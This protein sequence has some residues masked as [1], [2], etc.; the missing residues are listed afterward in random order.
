MRFDNKQFESNVSTTMSTLDKL[1]Q[2]LNFSG[3]AK[4]LE[5]VGTAAKNVNMN[6]LGDAVHAVSTKFS[7]MQ[8]MAVTALANITNSAINAG[9]RMVSALTI[10]PIKTGFSEYETQINATQT[11]L[12]NTQSKGSTIDDVNAALEEL[13]KYAD[14]TIYN[15]T[16]MTRNIGTFTAAGVDLETSVGA[17]QGIANLAAVSGSTSQQASTA[18][19]Q[20][21]QALSSGTVRLQ[22][23]NSVVNAGMGGEVFQN[24]LKKTSEQLGTGAEQAI[25]ASGSFRESLRDGWL[26]S[27]V[28]TE[29]LKKFTTSGANEYLAEYTGQ[30]QDVVESYIEQGKEAA[31]AA[32]AAG[33]L[34]EGVTEE[35]Y[36][37]DHASKALAEKSGK[38]QKEIK[39]TLELAQ[40]ATDAATKVKTFT[41]LWDVLKESAQSGWSQTWKI[42]VGDF[43]EAKGLLTPIAD[44]LTGFINRMSEM[45]NKIIE[46]ALG[47]GFADLSEKMKNVL[48]PAMKATD[49]LKETVKTVTDLG[50][51]VNKVIR[52]DFGNGE[53]RF[54]ALA[55][56]GY[57][58]CEVQNKVNETLGNSYRYTQEQIDAQNELLGKKKETAEASEEEG[59]ATGKLTDAQ[60]NRLKQLVM[61]TEEE[62]EAIGMTEE[63]V[64]AL[65]ELRKTAEK[66][67]MPLD[68]FIDKMDEI[69]GRWLMIEGF[70][71]LG[72]SIAEIFKSIGSAFKEIFNPGGEEEAANGLFNLIA[73][74]HKLSRGILDRVIDKADELKRIFKGIFAVFDIIAK[75]TGGALKI[76]FKVVTA[77]L[78][79]F[80]LS[81][82]DV[83][84]WI[85]DAIVKFRDWIDRVFD[86]DKI[87]GKLANG[88]HK[89]I[90]KIKTFVE[91]IKNSEGF[92]KFVGYLERTAEA[93]K[94]FFGS[95]K[96]SK[97]F[98]NMASAFKSFG[99]SIAKVFKNLKNSDNIPR[100]IILGLINGIKDGIPAIIGAMFEL[101]KA[102]LLGICE[103]LGIHSPSREFKEVGKNIVDGLIEGIKKGMTKVIEILK[104]LFGKVIEFAKQID[105]GGIL[106]AVIVIG[107]MK[108]INNLTGVLEPITKGMGSMLEGIGEAFQGLGKSLKAS[109]LKKKATAVLLFA[110]AVG[111]LA[112][113]LFLISKIPSKDLWRSVGALGALVGIVIVLATA[114]AGFSIATNKLEKEKTGTKLWEIALVLVGIGAAVML[115]A[116][117]VKTLGNMDNGAIEKGGFAIASFIAMAGALIWF[118]KVNGSA[119]GQV[120]KLL[121]SFSVSMFILAGVI[122]IFALMPLTWIAKG[123]AAIAGLAGIMAG[124]I[125]VTSKFESKGNKVAAMLLGA[126]TA[127]TLMA[128]ILWLLAP[129]KVK[130]I[131]KGELAMLGFVGIIGA[132]L[133]V[134]NL[135]KD[136]L[137][138]VSA[139]ILS[140]G[141]T[142]LI[143]ALVMKIC[144]KMTVKQIT[145]GEAVIIS[146]AGIISALIYM[147]KFAG[148][149]L[150]SVAV[151]L[152]AAAGAIAI[153]AG[154]AILLGFIP[155][156]NLKKG[157]TAVTLLGGLVVG[158]MQ[159]TRGLEQCKGAVIAMAVI[160]ALLAGAVVG[161][162]FIDPRKLGNAVVA[163]GT[164]IGMMALMFLAAGTMKEAKFGPIIAM[165]AMVVL[166][167]GVIW[168]LSELEVDTAFGTLAGIALVMVAMAGIVAL[169]SLVGDKASKAYTGIFALLLMAAP[170]LAFTFVL[171]Q[172]NGVTVSTETLLSLL[173]VVTLM[174]L[175]LPILAAVG[176]MG[177]GPAL[178]GVLALSAM[179]VPLALFALVLGGMQGLQNAAAN[180]KILMTLMTLMTLLL[181]PLLLIGAAFMPALMGIVA[182]GAM[183]VPMASYVGVLALMQNI[184]GAAENTDLLLNLMWQLT[185]M[186]LVLAPIGPL[187]LI[188]SGV[189]GIL[190]SLMT[191]VGLLAVA[192]GALFDKF[193][194]LQEFLNTGLPVMIQLAGAMGEMIGAFVA[195]IATQIASAL[196]AIAESMSLFMT[197]LQGFIDGAKTVD[198]KVLAGVAIIVA[199][200]LALSVAELFAAISAFLSGGM[201][202]PVLG[203][204]L[205]D[206]MVNAMPFVMTA[207]LIKPS[208]IDGVKALVSAIMM[209]TGANLLESITSW[210]TGE[211]SMEAFA[212]QFPILGQGLRGFL[213]S[214]GVLGEEE[215]ATI[216]CASQA[217]KTLAEASKTI[218]NTGGLLG[219]LVGNNDLG[220][221]AAQFPILGFGLRQ[222]LTNVGTF[223]DDE[224]ATVNCAAEA[225]KTLAESA[226]KIPNQGGLLADLIGDN[227][228]QTFAEQ[229]PH[230]GTGLRSFLT[231]V[232]TFTDAE[233][234]TVDCGARA[235]KLL[236]EAASEIPN[237]GGWWGKIAGENNLQH[238]ANQFPYL[239]SGLVNFL[240]S[241]GD[242]GFGEEQLNV[243]KFGA[244]AVAEIAKAA[245]TIPNSGGWWGKIVGENNLQDFAGQFPSLGEGLAGFIEKLGTFSEAQVTTVNAAAR[246]ITA[247]AELDEAK[248][249]EKNFDNLP[250][251]AGQ[252]RTFCSDVGGIT[253]QVVNT[254]ARNVRTIKTLIQELNTVD[255]TGAEDFADALSQLGNSS[256]DAFIDAFKDVDANLKMGT[257]AKSLMNKAI[258]GIEAKKDDF[259]SAC[260]DVAAAGPDAIDTTENVGKFESAGKDLGAGLVIGIN[261]KWQAVYDAAYALGQAAVQGEKDGQASNSPS[262]LTIQAGKWLGEGLVVGMDMMGNKVYNAGADLGKAATGNI[263]STISK[264]ADAVNTDIDSQP[265]IR[266]VL[267]L[268]DVESGA[269]AIGNMLNINPS[270]GVLANVG[271]ISSAMNQRSQNGVNDDV[272]SAIDRLNKKMNNFGNTTYHI[273]G[274]TYDDGSNISEAVRTIVRAARIERRV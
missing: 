24:A 76:A 224:I 16:E 21:S 41:Q 180:A 49:A 171:Q 148:Q 160:I 274:V 118:A 131:V 83:A 81:I 122:G 10:D 14:M 82:L 209:I 243:V 238:F 66:L 265:T 4:G 268:S 53:P 236:A 213:D 106:S 166:L 80:G 125:I 200:I 7:A 163:M 129:M 215:M 51:I 273:D 68:E 25:K 102:I 110:V 198:E 22:D 178:T 63:Q 237:Q 187:A 146:F 128:G 44:T 205:S 241:F 67:G 77:V 65:N 271:S 18:M 170:L 42:I 58:Y 57:N 29:T 72:K 159:S 3:S 5:D 174:T 228:M 126:A 31:K 226:K 38:N 222:F 97:E 69:D 75:I 116:L 221:F 107:I 181:I 151:T 219:D 141:A 137:A 73:G 56:A 143:M 260:T 186:L 19:Y 104:M 36:A 15:F 50:D 12:A 43:E 261:S 103:C 242:T 87:A 167:A 108:T 193:P 79:K 229:F 61:M 11:I 183:A 211:S 235:V 109:A 55:E 239:G 240:A 175:L 188:A 252:I 270:V 86:A 140:V 92:Q 115:F 169:L 212:A 30:S 9:K 256:V 157:I 177:V 150:G 145:K 214:V 88:L 37:I 220:V 155:L 28:L 263:S 112:G 245:D 251:I 223:S 113:A 272:V 162:S 130:N 101:G 206:F 1:K 23:W 46:S 184:K 191:T 91:N 136:N 156:E 17:I 85:G 139:V 138:K 33:E 152:L 90:L 64:A 84:A 161:L 40:T 210:L 45:R 204:Q 247:I 8:V 105:L 201:G 199:A 147:T 190:I 94:E 20:L 179:A 202:L 189:L 262:K 158:L 74:F 168:L 111:V 71:N 254:A 70:K 249:K 93:F 99:D 232:G 230:L 39:E 207:M 257:A 89:L 60:K 225:V 13:N 47:K 269:S 248:I 95:L 59:K 197:N 154:V 153:L 26:T 52:G 185:E 250:D 132:L 144:G 134:T 165:G 203:Q 127:M 266:P 244:Q 54:K 117:A 231:N 27:E 35:A 123:M 100:D 34:G 195:G 264:I 78:D 258:E 218:P 216:N 208:M 149:N 121:L 164:M 253:L 234:A 182:L 172:L 255:M 96:E 194:K 32:A 62:A 246:A 233:V 173:A 196:P 142:M 217:I 119:A 2:K 114:L 135:A 124:L 227:T 259:T 6:G 98:Q 267:D 133:L 192:I 120:A 48:S 176:G